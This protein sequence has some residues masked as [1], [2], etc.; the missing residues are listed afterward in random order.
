MDKKTLN[1]YLQV[2]TAE[3][4]ISLGVVPKDS[5]S[6]L[7]LI[8]HDR[9]IALRDRI[10]ASL[11][12]KI[13][14]KWVPLFCEKTIDLGKT[15]VTNTGEIARYVSEGMDISMLTRF[16][17]SGPITE[18]D[19]KIVLYKDRR[20]KIGVEFVEYIK[21]EET[22]EGRCKPGHGVYI[23][24]S[25]I[26]RLK[27]ADGKVKIHTLRDR[28]VA[29]EK[30][31][32]RVRFREK[33]KGNV[34]SEG[35]YKT[36]LDVAKDTRGTLVGFD[37]KEETITIA[38]DGEA[39]K[40]VKYF[41]MGLEDAMSV[42]E[43]S[44]LGQ[45]YPQDKEEVTM[46]RT[47]EE[48]FPKTKLDTERAYRAVIGL[49]M[50]NCNHMVFYGPPGSGKSSILADIKDI[51]KQ[52]KL[53]FHVKGCKVQCNPFSLTDYNGF[54]KVVPPCPECMIK[55][56]KGNGFKETGIFNI[57]DPKDVPVTVAE[58][59]QGKGI[60]M[61]QGRR[62][63]TTMHLTGM[64]IPKLDGA[65]ADENEFDPE[66]FH[67]GSFPRANNGLLAFEEM[68][69]AVNVLDDILD[70]I[71]SGVA[72]AEQL[73]FTYPS[74][75]V[76]IGTANDPSV[77]AGPLNDRM[78]LL[79]IRYPDEVDTNSR[80]TQ[81]GYHKIYTPAEAVPIEDIHTKERLDIREGIPMPMPIE[82]AVEAAYV[83]FRNE[84][85]G[86]GK[87]EISGSNRSKFDALD[88]ARVEL[89]MQEMFY[90]DTPKV[91][92]PEYAVKGVQFALCSR[93]SE[94]DKKV[95]QDCKTELRKWVEDNFAALV[96]EE[97]NKWWCEAYRQ[98]GNAKTVAPEM[99]ENFFHELKI[100]AEDPEAIAESF[101][102]VKAAYED[103]KMDKRIQ[104]AKIQYPMMDYLFIEQPR[105]ARLTGQALTELVQY[106]VTSEKNSDARKV[107]DKG[108]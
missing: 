19:G 62:K 86:K 9:L 2:K 20:S 15:E 55:H 96:K 18:K 5:A 12:D 37:E 106:Y 8:T 67:P 81:A 53:L 69:K 73:R 21:S 46:K 34:L 79:A 16:G 4:L 43:V 11:D 28:A 102:R 22:L 60:E 72:K 89:M 41:T 39:G 87:S 76:I 10:S 36:D 78:F 32:S 40:K 63:L 59:S 65:S 57:P 58:F 13:L 99:E 103:K 38:P 82:K 50:P 105:M 29:D 104:M 33:F 80:I 93:V 95:S 91:V 84:Y 44:T 61:L 31:G 68:D 47:L 83:K 94:R 48:F 97:E 70:M 3:D 52:Q 17:N 24:L 42:I 6:S 14:G 100:Y 45:I 35:R 7:A 85:A 49:L 88:V 30:T 27:F 1:Q 51:A 108:K 25:D 56:S 98:L 66:G 77:F 75:C 23:D 64:K 54:G 26:K 107:G 74:N 101:D 71:S 92:N 90:K